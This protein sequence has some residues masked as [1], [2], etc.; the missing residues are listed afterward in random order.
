MFLKLR[1]T[2]QIIGVVVIL[3]LLIGGIAIY[4]IIKNDE[5]G[6]RVQ[7]FSRAE[8]PVLRYRGKLLSE[9]LRQLSALHRLSTFADSGQAQQL[10]TDLARARELTKTIESDQ[11]EMRKLLEEAVRAPGSDRVKEGYQTAIT[12]WGLIE[13]AYAERA[14]PINQVLA[15]LSEPTRGDAGKPVKLKEEATRLVIEAEKADE[16]LDARMVDFTDL[17]NNLGKFQADEAAAAQKETLRNLIVA[18]IL[19]VALGLSLGL[20]IA[21][22]IAR[23]LRATVAALRNVALG[24]LSQRLVV[25]RQDEIGEVG[26]AVNTMQANLSATAKVAEAIARGNL[27]VEPVLLSDKDTL[28]Q[29]LKG[30]LENL[31]ATVSNIQRVAAEVASGSLQLRGAAGQISEGAS[32]QASSVEQTSSAM[33]E[34]AAGISQNAKNAEETEK[35]ATH[36]AEDA[37]QCVQSVQRTAASMKGI[38]EKIG[39]VEEITRKTELLALNASVEAARAG[40]HGRGFA[41]V[42]SEVSKLAEIS[43]QAAA[44][45][46]QSSVEGKEI[47]EATS[48]S[49]GEL[50]PRIEKTKDLVQ[51]I[52]ASSEEQS[53]G[54]G[55]VNQAVQQL[56]KVVQQNASAAQ[57]MAATAES[58]SDLAGELQESISFFRLDE[59]DVETNGP[60]SRPVVARAARPARAKLPAP[61]RKRPRGPV[62]LLGAPGDGTA[63]DPDTSDFK[64]Y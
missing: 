46:V 14:Q 35:I 44:E 1:L 57:Q 50:L 19:A 18:G 33:E 56:D 16:R 30:M 61:E 62:P 49:L 40:E 11:V 52:T 17:V 38:A 9:R 32:N 8:L 10:A 31:R 15:L 47:A 51:G 63:D 2:T 37:K 5:V 3:T 39:I 24:D 36:V 45:I 7:H 58:L 59:G 6:E 20:V 23:R 13:K 60:R 29:S 43:Q 4:A 64:K 42:A 55:Q 41:V 28:G 12:Q 54:A 25:G 21:L 27:T 48:R 22:S 26:E 34:M 53:I